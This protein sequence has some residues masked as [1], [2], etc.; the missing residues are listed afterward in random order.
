ML[1]NCVAAHLIDSRAEITVNMAVAITEESALTLPAFYPLWHRKA[2][3]KLVDGNLT[4]DP[5]AGWQIWQE[6]LRTR[7]SPEPPPFNA[8][9]E[10]ALLWCWPTAW[11]IQEMQ[12]SIASPTAL[13]EEVLGADVSETPDLP[14]ALQLVALAYALPQ[15]A[16]ELP[17]ETWW[18]LIERLHTTATQAHAQRLDWLADPEAVVVNQLLA[19]ELPLAVGYLFPEVRALRNLRIDART[20]LSEALIELTDGQGLPHARMLPILG[21]L[22]ACWT[23]CRWIGGQLRRGAWSRDAELQYEW[24]V[25]HAIRLARA[26]GRFLF[27]PDRA[28]I[29]SRA[30]QCASIW[31]E[32]LFKTAL[33]LAG[34]RGDHAAALEALPKSVVRKSFQPK[35]SDLPK[36]SLNSDW[37]GVTVMSDGWSQSAARIALAYAD[38]APTIEITVDGESLFAG[39]WEFET[40]CD[41]QPLAPISDWEQLC[42]ESGKQFDF[43]EIG[44]NLSAGLRL[45][46]QVLFGRKDRV[47]YLA[48]I[49]IA[50]DDAPRR[51]QHST[52]LPF[53][54]GAH[55]NPEAETRDGTITAG[56]IRAAVLPLGLHEWRADPRGGSLVEKNSSLVLSQEING[57]AICCPLWIDL[58]SKR[59]AEQRTWRQLT[60][61]EWMEV[62]PPDVAVGYRAQSGDD[63]WLLYRSLGPA[64]NRTLLGHNIAGEFCAGRFAGGKFKEWIEIEAV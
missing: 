57:R 64:G 61:A 40:T 30:D 4:S 55:W 38:G 17:A 44:V 39:V 49:I 50:S 11:R 18:L 5:V 63:Q 31:D 25:R 53:V 52:S 6:H 24:L 56:H 48:D 12:A 41:D 27:A 7:D 35:R 29:V 33:K 16:N 60:V 2:P 26:D 36:S 23:R 13:A 47:L 51:I 28:G 62:I 14:A 19:G 54:I 58:K 22:F 59:S 32:S 45:E 43:L 9:N 46:R 21:P 8:G 20:V 34:D 37:A 15:L 3:R 1:P 10:P 42:W